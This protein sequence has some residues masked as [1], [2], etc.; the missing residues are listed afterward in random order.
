MYSPFFYLS[1]FLIQFF[2]IGS[3]D[4]AGDRTMRTFFGGVVSLQVVITNI[5]MLSIVLYSSALKLI[6][7]SVGTMVCKAL[8]CLKNAYLNLIPISDIILFPSSHNIHLD[9]KGVDKNLPGYC[10]SRMD[11]TSVTL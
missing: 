5:V 7:I 2:M 9:M 11:A 6:V 10:T 1:A 3:V 4:V 8:F